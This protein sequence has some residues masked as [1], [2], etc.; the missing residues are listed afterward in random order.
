MQV[1]RWICCTHMKMDTPVHS[2]ELFQERM[3][4]TSK[5]AARTDHTS[6]VYHRLPRS[7]FCDI[8]QVLKLWPDDII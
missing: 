8:E 5:A 4:P 7:N 6:P 1:V 3:V 2:L